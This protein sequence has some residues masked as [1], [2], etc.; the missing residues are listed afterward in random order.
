MYKL[1]IKVQAIHSLTRHEGKCEINAS[2]ICLFLE[3]QLTINLLSHNVRFGTSQLGGMVIMHK[4][5]TN[6]Y[7]LSHHLSE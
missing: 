6:N 1:L 5:I 2:I 7:S 3:Y 4:L